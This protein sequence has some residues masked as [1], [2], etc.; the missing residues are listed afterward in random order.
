MVTGGG[1]N[2][3]LIYHMAMCVGYF[4][5]TGIG[6][7]QTNLQLLVPSPTIHSYLPSLPVC[8]CVCVCVCACVRSCV[9][10]CVRECVCVGGVVLMIT[11]VCARACVNIPTSPTPSDRCIISHRPTSRSS[12]TRHSNLSPHSPKTSPL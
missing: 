10:V 6:T 8:T 1:K 12:L 4:I 11:C 9:R 5:S 7:K 2:R 3:L